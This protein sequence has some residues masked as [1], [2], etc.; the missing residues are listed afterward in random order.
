MVYIN[1]VTI[2]GRVLSEPRFAH[3][4]SKYPG[5]NERVFLLCS[6]RIRTGP[7]P[8]RRSDS[9]KS[10]SDVVIEISCA[11][12]LAR[13]IAKLPLRIGDEVVVEGELQE[14]ARH[15]KGR[16]STSKILYVEPRNIQFVPPRPGIFQ[17]GRTSI[18]VEELAR[19]RALEKM[20]E[21]WALE[22]S[23]LAKLK[24][25]SVELEQEWR[26]EPS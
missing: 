24:E 15:V 5:E 21:T 23:A 17:K 20:S 8:K 11:G 18:E 26:D 10:R 1:N 16:A 25:I 6:L 14:R 7:N 19:L 3:M 22:P 4:E 2:S 13:A 9:R 12:T